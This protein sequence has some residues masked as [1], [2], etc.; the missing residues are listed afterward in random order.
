MDVDLHHPASVA[1]AV[2]LAARL[3]ES[4]R[5]VAGGTDLVIQMARGR[6]APAHLIDITR[7]PGLDGI[8]DGGDA[9]VIGALTTHKSIERHPP[10]QQGL[11]ALVE[12]A[13]VIGGHQ[14]RNIATVGGN[15]V[16]ASPAADLVPALLVLDAEAILVSEAGE[17]TVALDGFLIGPG[18]SDRRTGE[19]LR[20][21]RFARPAPFSATAFLKAGRRKAMEISVV[22]AAA[23]LTLDPASGR[24]VRARIAAG[25]VGPRT[26]RFERAEQ[27]L[28]GQVPTPAL[29]QAAAGAAAESC[30][31]IDDVR[32]SAAF[33]RLLV[34]TL[35]GRTLAA[36]L[37]R[38]PGAHP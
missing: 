25:A 38:I 19:L 26:L 8:V 28:E 1:D 6:T 4:A 35:V 13:R 2:A 36:C 9:I 14:V 7:L 5:F 27:L 37:D 29:L 24:C 3:G 10:F 31:P 22:C 21:V 23:S 32:A 20:A 33:R 17:R 16:N 34:Q 11:I 18:R 12:A 30:R 15:I